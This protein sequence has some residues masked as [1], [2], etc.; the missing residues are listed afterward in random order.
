MT[1]KAKLKITP[2]AND[3]MTQAQALPLKL[4]GNAGWPQ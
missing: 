1:R 2:F 4:N 3:G